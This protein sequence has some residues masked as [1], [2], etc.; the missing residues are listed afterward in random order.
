MAT[1]D[2]KLFRQGR[3]AADETPDVC[4][5]AVCST[6]QR[7]TR[8]ATGARPRRRSLCQRARVSFGGCA[9]QLG[10]LEGEGHRLSFMLF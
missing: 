4:A 10:Y 3:A 6:G 2:G 7:T 8:S 5:T 1:A 9:L